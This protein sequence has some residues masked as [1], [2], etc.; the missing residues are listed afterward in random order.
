MTFAFTTKDIFKLM[1]QSEQSH[2]EVKV[3]ILYVSQIEKTWN[4]VACKEFS[5]LFFNAATVKTNLCSLM[6][7][8]NSCFVTYCA[9]TEPEHNSVPIKTQKVN[10]KK[11]FFFHKRKWKKIQTGSYCICKCVI[12]LFY[13]TSF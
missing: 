1:I 9:F 6:I 4:E 5:F 3:F 13:E 11:I 7:V 2:A 12:I 10:T 8:L